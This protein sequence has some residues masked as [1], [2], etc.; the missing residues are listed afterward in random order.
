MTAER[1]GEGATDGSLRIWEDPAIRGRRV[2]A[3]GGEAVPGTGAGYRATFEGRLT[4]R[5]LAQGDPP[6]SW[7][8]LG[9]LTDAPA[10]FESTYVWCEESYIYFLDDQ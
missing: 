10:D 7:F 3:D 1:P 4:G 6:W 8:E 9:E 5:R 2:Q